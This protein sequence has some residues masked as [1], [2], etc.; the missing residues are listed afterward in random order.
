MKLHKIYWGKKQKFRSAQDEKKKKGT[1]CKNKNRKD[2]RK[3]I[4]IYAD[5]DE[6]E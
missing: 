1:S 4:Y 5:G 2:F 6:N 3:Y